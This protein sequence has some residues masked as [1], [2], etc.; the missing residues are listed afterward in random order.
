MKSDE[1]IIDIIDQFG[2]EDN[3]EFRK[4]LKAFRTQVKLEALSKVKNAMN[5]IKILYK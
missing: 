4:A 3:R 2:D 1:H 5:L